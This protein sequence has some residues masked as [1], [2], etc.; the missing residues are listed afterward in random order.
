MAMGDYKRI[1]SRCILDLTC[2]R[3]APRQWS[4]NIIASTGI[5]I[6]NAEEPKRFNNT[7][8]R[9]MCLN[10]RNPNSTFF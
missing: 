4:T 7:L 6:I 5:N 3:K 10:Q 2:Q 8:T 1:I 9:K